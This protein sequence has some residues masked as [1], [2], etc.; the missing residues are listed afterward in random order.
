M[1]LEIYRYFAS[2]WDSAEPREKTLDLT[3]RLIAEGTRNKSKEQE[4]KAI[5]FKPADKKCFKCNETRHLA[6][7]CTKAAQTN[8]KNKYVASDVI[9]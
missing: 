4:E 7:K 8:E 2:T 1:L 9:K 5:A 6:K 3:A